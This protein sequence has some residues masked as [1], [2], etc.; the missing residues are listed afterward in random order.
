MQRRLPPTLLDEVR[1][2]QTPPFAIAAY[3]RSHLERRDRDALA[4]RHV[5]DRR[6]RPLLERQHDPGL[7]PGKS[8][9]VVLAEAE[10]VD[11]A[12][13]AAPRRAA[14]RCVIVPTFEDCARICA[15]VIVSVPRVLGLVDDA[16]GDLDR[17]RERERVVGVTRLSSSA[18]ATVTILNVE[19]GS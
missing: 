1:R 7:S 18:A 14:A 13:R 8:T 12:T 17:R 19:P 2:R 5:A 16:V 4:D 11:P 3:A 6:A 10:P 15:T 9:P